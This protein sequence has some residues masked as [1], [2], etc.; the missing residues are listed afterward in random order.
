MVTK[1]FLRIS[2]DFTHITVTGYNMSLLVIVLA[3]YL[4]LF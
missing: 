1:I 4:M 2:L 3:P